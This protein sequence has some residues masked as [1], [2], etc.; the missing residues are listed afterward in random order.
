MRLL[1]F[2]L[3]IA[4]TPLRGWAGDV[5]SVAM[6]TE[7]LTMAHESPLGNVKS[8]PAHPDC[9]GHSGHGTTATGDSGDTEG[10]QLAGRCPT[11]S[12]CQVCSSAA[13]ALQTRIPLLLAAPHGLP[14]VGGISY[15]S[16]DQAPG[17]KPPI[18]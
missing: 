9:M 7:Q 10:D 11:C 8:S 16:A 6:A 3:L 2:I 1:L 5:M 18:S 12:A 15:T 13:L 4:L 14:S 17:F